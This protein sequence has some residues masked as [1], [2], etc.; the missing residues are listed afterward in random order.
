MNLEDGNAT[1]NIGL[2]EHHLAIKAPWAQQR[3][4]KHIGTV[5][6]CNDN[7]IRMFIKAIQFNKQLVE[8]LLTFI[9][10]T[11]TRVVSLAAYSVNLIDEDDA[12]RMF[13]S[14]FKKI[15]HSRSSNTY[16]HLYKFTAANAVDSHIS[17]SEFVEMFVGVG[18][19]RV[20]DLFKEAK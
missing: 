20:R 7:N 1:A 15:A 10:T 5:G 11:H 8:R 4:I 6:S 3:R 9:I 12:W 18:A 17:G 16:A 2:I 13:F 19:A 14:L